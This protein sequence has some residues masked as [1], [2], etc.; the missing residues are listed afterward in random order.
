MHTLTGKIAF[1]G[2]GNMGEALIKGLLR[3]HIVQPTSIIASEPRHDRRAELSEK[4]GVQMVESNLEAATGA[5]V[6]VLA[7]KP[8]IL[9][10]VL[11]EI[12]SKIDSRCV[13]I[14][15]AAGKDIAGIEQHLGAGR[16]V[17]RAMPNVACLVGE[18]ATGLSRGEHVSSEDLHLA[19]RIFDSVGIS[20]V[21]DENLLDAVT[22]LSGSGPAYIFMI[23]EALADA[24]VKMG[25]SRWDSY[26]LASQTV[27][28]AA[29]LVIESKEHPGRL[30]D[31]VC[32]PGGC[33]IAAVHTLEQG[34]LR[35]TL[36][37][38]VEVA[39][40][41]SKELGQVNNK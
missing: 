25:L 19:C 41:R 23:V 36:I 38:A 34:G 31:M 16:R 11:E 33:A 29:K 35:T 4:Y 39:T 27:L 15:I 7:V 17:V 28:G 18:G 3:A 40:Q 5:A 9:S 1:I 14:S 13:V 10:K 26:K 6:V 37:N 24:G 30:K 20:V 8:Q 32:S 22:G 21:L 12:S 2:A